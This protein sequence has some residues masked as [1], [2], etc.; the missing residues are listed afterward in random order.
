M[1]ALSA[2][3]YEVK[4]DSDWYKETVDREK[5]IKEASEIIKEKNYFPHEGFVL[6]TSMSFGVRAAN[7]DAE[8]YDDQLLKK[9]D[10]NGIRMFKKK[11]PI[12]KEI[13][14]IFGDIEGENPFKIYDVFGLNNAKKS[15]WIGD[16]WF[17]QVK[18][19]DVVKKNETALENEIREVPYQEYLS[20]LQKV[21]A[22][23]EESNNG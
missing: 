13:Q 1:H 6:F 19:D 7:S 18:N 10:R 5:K 8:L 21:I 15:Q 14:E 12:K 9:A 20:L 4:Q 17:F 3:I 16:R 23:M 11:S 2:P 22:E